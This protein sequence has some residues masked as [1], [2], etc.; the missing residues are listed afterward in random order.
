MQNLHMIQF[1]LAKISPKLDRTLP[2]ILIGNIKTSLL[3]NS[4][5][6]LQ[7][8]LG[9]LMKD[10]KDLDFYDFAVHIMKFFVSKSLLLLLL[11][12]NPA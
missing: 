10:F 2:A 8:A 3:T 5:T 11:L 4:F 6:T 1:W 12:H 7:I 9:V